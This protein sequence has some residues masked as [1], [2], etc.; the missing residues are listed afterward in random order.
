MILSVIIPVYQVE[1]TIDRCVDSVLR[2]CYAYMEVILVD[3]GSTDGSPAICDAWAAKDN[4]ITVIHKENGGLSDAR[5]AGIDMAKGDY[6]TFVD[7]DDYVDPGVF[8]QLMVVLSEHP[9]YDILEYGVKKISHNKSETADFPD[10]IYTPKEYW[11]EG[12]A[13]QHSYA[14]NKIYRKG[15][16]EDVRFPKG[17]VFEDLW[18]LPL[19]T[20]KSKTIATASV[21]HY[22]YCWN[23]K[24]IT[25]TAKG[26]EL[27]MLLLAHIQLMGFEE[28]A[29]ADNAEYFM[30]V[31]NIQM[32]VHELTGN[33]PLLANRRVNAIGKLNGK[34]KLKAI[35][36]NIL[37]LRSLCKLNKF[38]HKATKC[39]S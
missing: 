25:A 29:M 11:N 7:S 2:Q 10:R 21:G 14:C 8:S 16:F 30:G 15:V 19:L 36:L 28:L 24:G 23:P 34:L 37:G 4:R 20:A 6:I 26:K 17:K 35:M 9:E 38:I 18:T 1:H 39:L 31:V 27:N 33:A 3:D 22:N 5:N 12:K 13:Y 32:D